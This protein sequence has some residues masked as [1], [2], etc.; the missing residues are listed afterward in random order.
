MSSA[1]PQPPSPA[2]HPGRAPR[3]AQDVVERARLSVVPRRRPQPPRV[4]FVVLVGLS[5][6]T[7]VVGLLLFN[8]SLQQASFATTALEKQASTLSAREQSLRMD[9]DEQRNPQRVARRAQA[10]GMVIPSVPTFLSL[11]SGEVQGQRTPATEADRFPIEAPPVKNPYGAPPSSTTS[12]T[13]GA[14]R[15]G[16]ADGRG[17]TNES[18]QSQLSQEPRQ[19]QRAQQSRR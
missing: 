11:G 1:L 7:G 8:T 15:D 5:L 3:R 9:L 17:T 12:S 13:T 6:L 16:A 10:L 4:P 18:R 14:S 2:G 19:S